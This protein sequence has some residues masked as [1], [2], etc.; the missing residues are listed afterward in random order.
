MSDSSR[1]PDRAAPTPGPA[2]PPVKGIVAHFIH[3]KGTIPSELWNVD[4]DSTNH[5]DADA[6]PDSEFI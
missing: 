6:D 5:P 1:P 3:F 4:P 2:Y